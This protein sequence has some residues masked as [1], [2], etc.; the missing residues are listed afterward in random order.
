[1]TEELERLCAFSD[2]ITFK[3]ECFVPFKQRQKKKKKVLLLSNF[4][5]LFTDLSK[6]VKII[7]CMFLQEKR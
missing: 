5:A 7:I 3:L 2:F 6:L 1:M 4:V